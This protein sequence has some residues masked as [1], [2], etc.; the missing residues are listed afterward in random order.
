MTLDGRVI[1][2]IAR[3]A[4]TVGARFPGTAISVQVGEIRGV[5]AGWIVALAA[6]EHTGTNHRL[7]SKAASHED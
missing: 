1:V 2:E 6:Q 5:K 4:E 3:I 7:E